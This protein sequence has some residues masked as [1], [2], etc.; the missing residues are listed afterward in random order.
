MAKRAKKV[1][2][3]VF[4]I[5]DKDYDFGVKIDSEIEE[6]ACTLSA[7]HE[8]EEILEMLNAYREFCDKLTPRCEGW[9]DHPMSYDVRISSIRV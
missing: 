1:D 8:A 9:H 3:K 4:F 2:K 6:D 7:L 5:C